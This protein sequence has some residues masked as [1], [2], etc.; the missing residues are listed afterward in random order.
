MRPALRQ[1][2]VLLGVVLGLTALAAGRAAAHAP[3]ASPAVIA[4]IRLAGDLDESAGMAESLL[5][6]PA[7]TFRAKLDRIHKA[8]KDKTVKCLY[9]EIDGLEIGWGK[10]NELRAA[11]ADFRAA[12][13]RAY[14][15]LESG[16]AV[17]YL[18]A[19]ACDEIA[20]P[21]SG[22]LLL[23]GVRY[24]LS[25]YRGLFD[26][27]GLHADM[28]QMGDFKGAGETFTLSLMSEANRKQW[29][30]VVDD[31]YAYLVETAAASRAT[32]GLTPEKVRALIDEGP[33]TAKQAVAHGLVD[34]LAYQDQL[35]ETVKQAAGDTRLAVKKDYA[36]QKS[37]DLDLSNPFALLKL[38]SGPKDGKLNDKPKVAVIYATGEI[39]TGKSSVSL[40]GGSTVGST[41]LIEAI[42][43][44]EE[45]PTVKAIV[46]RVDSP[47]G[48]A[49][50]SD[51]I[52][53]ELSRCQKPVVASMSDTAASGGYYISMAARK[54][55]AEPG[56]L[57][58]S[59]G[60]VGGKIVYGELFD[61]VG[62]TT[63]SVSRGKNSGVMSGT[64]RFTESEKKAML[65]TMQDVYDQ[66][67]DKALAGRRRAGK[68]MTRDELKALAG[69][70]IWTGRQAKANGLVDELGTLDD[71]VAEAKALAGLKPGDE[72]E[73]LPLPKARSF[74]DSLIDSGSDASL[75]LQA[76]V[77]QAGLSPLEARELRPH[78]R[79]IEQF[80]RLRHERVWTL[81][82]YHAERK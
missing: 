8:K 46:L 79:A 80:L 42:R 45:E 39:V 37:G 30:S 43:K 3:D 68:A 78:L 1:C 26:K 25:F 57:T 49:L 76:A 62:I 44:A 17:D 71:A 24:E 51:L 64:A 61:K 34:R 72:V 58:G 18:V 59:I 21:E 38:L 70:R 7:E 47:G 75:T 10:V 15:Y 28:M 23:T 31:Y 35:Q 69:G 27:L 55:Y 73:I 53:R 48:S 9:L 4:H 13:K 41:T 33:F 60:V 5:G 63:E 66:F 67:L 82:P 11:I 32:R 36:R 81:M 12:G 40:L 77:A 6:T 19:A 29:Q 16:S 14:A 50:A 65:A 52:W 2:G 22:T 54:I 74:L 56:T 20:M